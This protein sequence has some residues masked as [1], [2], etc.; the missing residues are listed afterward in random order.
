VQP[1]LTAEQMREVDR[2]AAS[3]GT[4]TEVLVTRAGTAVA[5]E[6][7]RMLRGAYGARVV[8]VAGRGNNGADG[9]VAASVLRRRGAQVLVLDARE[10]PAR[11]PACDLVIDAA[12]GT[13][14]RGEYLAP[15]PGGAP[16]LA[17]DLPTGVDADSGTAGEGAVAAVATVTFG[18]LKPGLLVGEGRRRAGRVRLEP[19]GL[20]VPGPGGCDA[21]LVEDGD[22]AELVPRR[23]AETHKWATAVAVVAG[24]PGMYG[25]ATYV[26][27]AAMRAGAGMVRLGI[28]GAAPADLPVTEAVSRALPASGF[29]E[30]ALE[31]LERCKALV[32]GPGLGPERPTRASVRR[33]VTRAPVPAVVD[34]DGLRALG[35]E[36]Q[37]AEVLAPRSAPT[38]LTPHDGELA[39][40]TGSP[41]GADRF[42]AVRGAAARTG[43]VVL[44]KGSTTLVAEPSG[45]VLVST[46]GSSRLAT[47]GTG[48][49]L[50]GVVGAF[51]ARGLGPLEAAA[52]A[53]HVHGRAAELG[54]AEGLLAG[55]L[56]ELVAAV[57]SR[58]LGA[59]AGRLG[60][61]GGRA[62]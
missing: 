38:V 62:G 18:A 57:L 4:P 58:A 61:G 51:L 45:R 10:A 26:A 48:D 25:A 19:I 30:P 47:A 34:A 6:A 21:L 8:V 55:D 3:S 23:P 59:G 2:R 14:F 35:G 12:Y 39:R 31:G 42:A 37:A 54:P 15:D 36:A 1:V 16:V 32:V 17:V 44:L 11:L 53:A 29:D 24:S 56:P 33:L 49:V 40:L 13:G 50:S 28:P 41:P 27:R 7:L 46:S 20:P 52:L 60:Q 9:R 5:N 43:V 22:V